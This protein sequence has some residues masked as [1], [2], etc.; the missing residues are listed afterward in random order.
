[1]RSWTSASSAGGSP[2]RRTKSPTSWSRRSW[3]PRRAASTVPDMRGHTA[4]FG[5][6]EL[7]IKALKDEFPDL[8]PARLRAAVERAAAKAANMS[9]NTEGHRFIDLHLQR[10]EATEDSTERAKIQREFAENLEQQRNDMDRALVVRLAAFS[11]APVGDDLDALLRLAQ[12][13]QRGA[14]L[15]LEAMSGMVDSTDDAA[16]KRLRELAAAWQQ[17]GNA[18]RAADCLERVLAIVPDDAT[19]HEAL[20]LFYRSTNEWSVLLDLLGRR[21]LHVEDKDKAELLRE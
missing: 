8:D 15:P 21:A 18:P 2:R 16:P 19:A 3:R 20:E 9:L 17:Q 11:E 6:I 5:S 1:M 12:I 10:V 14:E 7:L 13:T 4:G